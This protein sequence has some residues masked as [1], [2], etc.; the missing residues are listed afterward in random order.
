MMEE[1]QGR[2]RMRKRLRLAVG[3]VVLLLAIFLVPPLVSISHYKS[4]ITHLI[5]VS[6]GR[7]VRLSSVRVR[8]F[9]WP[10]FVLTDL[11]VSEDPAYGS[12]PVLHANTVTASI[13]L[14]SLWRG[15]IEIGKISVDEASL[16]LVHSAPG[17]WN[18]D[19]IFRTAAKAG[20]E[21]QAGRS[22][23]LPYL[24][25][26]NSR[27]NIKNGVEKLPFS[28]I[29]TDLSFWQEEPGNWRI[30]L[31]GQPARTDV[32]LDLADTGIVRLEASVHGAPELRQM[33]VRLDL[34]W[35]EA[36][37]G[38]L[39]RL[40][41]GS[42]PG[43]RGDLTAD[44][45]LEGTPNAAQIKTRL[46]ATG[47]HRA[48]FAPVAAMDFD[49]NCGFVY[50]YS[51]RSLD[52]LT[53][54][55]PLGD[56]RVQ[57]AG[58]LPG[59]DAAP[60]FS[61]ALNQVPV[62]AGLGLLRTIRSGVAPDLDASGTISGNMN[63]AESAVET[64]VRTRQ[65]S[66]PAPPVASG[67]TA[68][69]LTGS[70]TI[71]S[72]QLRG[73]GLSQPFRAAK[74]VLEPADVPPGS[75]Q[76]IA[77]TA[78]FPAG[79]TEP[80]N[81]GF[82]LGLSGYQ[83]TLRGQAALARAREMAHEAGLAKATMLD[84]LAGDP[85]TLDL[86]AEGPWL[87]QQAA[88]A[89]GVAPLSVADAPLGN[90]ENLPSSDSLSGTV[91]LHKANWKADYL[92]S[93]VMIGDA[94]LH[95][96]DGEIRW[97]PVDFSYGSVKGTAS[98]TLPSACDTPGP[99]PAYFQAEFGALNASELQATI[100]GTHERG[101]LLSS[102]I[103]R[104]H[105]SPE[106][107][108]PPLVGTVKAQ[109]LTVGPMTLQK[110]AAELRIL[111]TGIEM[112][113]LTAGLLGGK[114]QASGTLQ[115]PETRNGKPSYTFEGHLDKS[116]AAA[117]GA[118]V[119][120]HW[121]GGGLDANG[122]FEL[123]GFTGDDLAASAKG[124]LHFDWQHGALGRPSSTAWK[125]GPVPAALGRFD[126][127]SGDAQAGDGVLTLKQSQ[128]LTGGG[129]QTVVAT[130]TLSIPPRLNFAASRPAPAQKRPGASSIAVS[131]A[132]QQTNSPQRS[133]R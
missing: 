5:S 121:T 19:P 50:H 60:H 100:L 52:N 114:V 122:K 133:G 78:V 104:L 15:R 74:I 9:P 67:H 77:G 51:Q 47:V 35:R 23:A 64:S 34:E 63:Y 49:A 32:S 37:L 72:F 89:S 82:R 25:A 61:V 10:G 73:N 131:D 66:A 124:A 110:P 26:T 105:L 93:H 80:L 108:W 120:M 119:G 58:D 42:D 88:T 3:V 36:E 17:L 97:D 81:V 31:R 70:F 41:T 55:S 103:D 28:L 22:V 45:H 11:T 96:G 21:N 13:R 75:P 69:Q 57:L 84:A 116:S 109:S 117:V 130:V 18:L 71:D 1:E 79:G 125:A 112:G 20:H 46:R 111:P 123:S 62:A 92:A 76:A 38:Q 54:D 68:G 40:L 128:V 107:T 85:A 29:N 83:V 48:E 27:I 126:H 86:T 118:L 65:K 98:L 12:E 33:P 43:W 44:L 30:R 91:T 6:V 14:L 8:L 127:W 7:P 102:L 16:N 106:S 87:P 132:R 90:A 56:G 101:T 113:N 39:A 24:V 129:K 4:Q 2:R 59:G 53:C 94:T 95:L 115:P 99:C